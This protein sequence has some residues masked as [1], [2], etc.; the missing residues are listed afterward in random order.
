M[1]TFL[2]H[3]DTLLTLGISLSNLSLSNLTQPKNPQLRWVFEV[4]F[5]III[6]R[7]AGCLAGPSV[8]NPHPSSST[9]AQSPW[10]GP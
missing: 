5:E 9:L 10:P 3:I 1:D 4:I 2:V 6:L 8:P 7:K